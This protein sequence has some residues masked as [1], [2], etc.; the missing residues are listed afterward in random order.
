MSPFRFKYEIMLKKMRLEEKK[1]SKA[2]FELE[3]NEEILKTLDRS[4]SF[5]EEE[6]YT[7]MVAAQKSQDFALYERLEQAVQEVHVKQATLEP[8]LAE[9][10][11][12]KAKAHRA[13]IEVAAER[14]KWEIVRERHLL[15]WMKKQQKEEEQLL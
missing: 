2:L 11:P 7:Q 9:I 4:L 1:C 12:K 8:Q 13:L 6:L 3:K 15:E 10:F 5:E 14:K